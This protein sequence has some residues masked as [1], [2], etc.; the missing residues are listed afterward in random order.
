[1]F[2]IKKHIDHLIQTLFNT[3]PNQFIHDYVFARY[4]PLYS[5]LVLSTSTDF[6]GCEM[7]DTETEEQIQDQLKQFVQEME[8]YGKELDKF[9]GVKKIVLESFLDVFL[10]TVVGVGDTYSFL[11]NCYNVGLVNAKST[12]QDIE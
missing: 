5:D 10:N 7:E 9:E 3:E 1:M 2:I 12:A 6:S 11:T 8:Y 4:H